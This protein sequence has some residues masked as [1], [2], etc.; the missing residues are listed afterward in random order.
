VAVLQIRAMVALQPAPPGSDAVA[1]LAAASA[2]RDG[3]NP[4]ALPIQPEALPG[5]AFPRLP[6]LYP[7]LLAV[8]TIPLTYLPLQAGINVFMLLAFLEAALLCWALSR[9]IGWPVALGMVFLYLQTWVT[10]YFGQIGFLMALLQYAALWGIMNGR[11][12]LTGVTL[13]V[14]A[15]FKITPALGL[16]ILMR[17]GY[18]HALLASLVT[19]L[20][21]VALTWPIAG[22]ERWLEGSL[23]ALRLQWRVWWLASWTGILTYYLPSPYGLGLSAIL[24]LTA[25]GYTLMRLGKLPPELGLSALLLLPILF[26]RTTWSHHSVA[27]LPV[28]AILWRRSAGNKLLVSAAWLLMAAFDFRGVPPGITLCWV[29][30][31]WPEQMRILDAP[32]ERIRAWWAQLQTQWGL[33]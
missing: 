9:W 20:V 2:L 32:A 27:A 16:L 19:V 14:G 12:S 13:A 26:A 24:G 25:L 29:A 4:Y 31:V 15:L 21:V 33:T 7:P 1:Y 11:P 10:V 5:E 28:L 30:C 17:R 8:L 22:L 6:Y 18:R 3:Q 23:M